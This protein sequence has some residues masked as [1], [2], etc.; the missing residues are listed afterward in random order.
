[1]MILV[2]KSY[3]E[4]KCKGSGAFREQS[5]VG[6]TIIPWTFCALLPPHLREAQLREHGHSHAQPEHEE[7][8]SINKAG[9]AVAVFIRGPEYA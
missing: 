1:M 6:G 4:R 7:E 8:S 5:F 9:S 3:L 2:S